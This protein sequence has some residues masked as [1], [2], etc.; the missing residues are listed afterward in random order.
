MEIGFKVE[1]I[2]KT[3][4]DKGEA[5]TYHFEPVP[6]PKVGTKDWKMT[7]TDDVAED[8]FGELA[9]GD[10]IYIETTRKNKQ[11]KIT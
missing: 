7:I 5:T 1:R 3:I 6:S 9:Y 8:L 2:S 10:I 11:A 4:D